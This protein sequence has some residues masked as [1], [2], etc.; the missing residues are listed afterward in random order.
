MPNTLVDSNVLID[1]LSGDPEWSAWS[2]AVLADVADSGQVV[3]N[4]LV[5][6]EVS[7]GF[8]SQPVFEEALAAI[9]LLREGL[10]W[11]AAFMAGKM[12]LKYRRGGGR[13]TAPLPDLYIG[14]HAA[15]AGMPLLTRDEKIYRKY[16]PK[17]RL[18]APK[19]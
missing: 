15:V 6:A 14:A 12:F 7:I 1:V 8:P 3:I 19:G 11:E 18:I 5:Y 2:A 17:L 16:F 13:K 9:P 4:P 10:P